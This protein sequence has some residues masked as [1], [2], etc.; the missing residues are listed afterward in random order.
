MKISIRNQVRIA[1]LYF[2]IAA[3]LGLLLRFWHVFDIDVNYKFIKHGHSHIALLGWVYV[4][5]TTILYVLFVKQE[6][7]VASKY[8]WGF[9]A[10]Q[11]T[12][13]GML[14]TF[15]IQGYAFLSITF[16]TLFLFASYWFTWFFFKNV[17]DEIKTS[18][19]FPYIK[20]SLYYLVLSSIGPWALGGIMAT[21][22]PTSVWYRLAIYFYLHFQYNGWMLL[23]LL[24]ILLFV[25]ERGGITLSRKRNKNLFLLIN[26]SVVLTALLS[27]LWTAPENYVYSLSAFGAG[28]QVICL[29]YVLYWIRKNKKAVKRLFT[30]L[31]YLLFIIVLI[32]LSIK[33]LLQ[34][35]GSF[36][37]FAN[38]S[39]NIIELTIAYLHWI[40]LGVVSIALF[41]ILDVLKLIRFNQKMIY[42]YLAGFVLTEGLLI[43]KGIAI[44]SQAFTVTD[45]FNE[46]L[47]AASLLLFMAIALI[48]FI[49]KKNAT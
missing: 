27:A 47:L 8:N 49:P 15:P 48:L 29:G 38:L 2:L 26:I 19:S 39:S 24:G 41:L 32:V 46:Y 45:F 25:M 7:R 36:P 10:T 1:L 11:V 34:L 44:W 5:L 43:Y 28:I 14:L 40:F 12:L 3:S 20:A 21:L 17:K 16:S 31:Q 9:I 13:V 30:A 6:K 22:G 42:F 18:A 33:L 4:C 23:A 37:Y 35:V